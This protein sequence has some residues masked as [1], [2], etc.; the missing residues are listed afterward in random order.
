MLGDGEEVEFLELLLGLLAQT[1]ELNDLAI[2]ITLD[3]LGKANSGNVE[4]TVLSEKIVHLIY[5]LLMKNSLPGESRESSGAFNVKKSRVL[6][7]DL[8]NQ[9]YEISGNTVRVPGSLPIEKDVILNLELTSYSYGGVSDIIDISLTR[10]GTYD[11]LNLSLDEETPLLLV[12]LEEPLILT[13]KCNISDPTKYSCGYY[14]TADSAWKGDGCRLTMASGSLCTMESTH[15]SLFSVKLTSELA[16][17]SGPC[18]TSYFPIYLLLGGL[19]ISCL[20]F[21]CFLVSPPKQVIKRS[22]T[23][24]I[25]YSGSMTG[26]CNASD[27]HSIGRRGF[28]SI[29]TKESKKIVEETSPVETPSPMNVRSPVV[30]QEQPKDSFASLFVESHLLLNFTKPQPV[31]PL[32]R[33]AQI[34]LT[35]SLDIVISGILLVFILHA[36]TELLGLGT[37]LYLGTLSAVLALVIDVLIGLLTRFAVRYSSLRVPTL[38]IVIVV[39][40]SAL[41]G[42]IAFSVTQCASLSESIGYTA[43]AGVSIDLLV[44]Q[45]LLAGLAGLLKLT[46]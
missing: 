20:Y 15:T 16:Y 28:R 29:M 13:L 11:G 23:K 9:E 17:S 22:D 36:G 19:S 6:G 25:P 30:P 43:L 21:I 31:S 14:D 3:I 24:V 7:T 1:T 2:E 41:S 26:D 37:Y 35:I 38:I 39:L 10:S 4:I 8:L 12:N 32:F 33:A 27:S 44:L 34:L 45:S 46:K 18:G 5:E 42:S 40:L